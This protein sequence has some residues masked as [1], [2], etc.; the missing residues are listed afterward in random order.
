MPAPIIPLSPIPA[1]VTPPPGPSLV[2]LRERV[3]AMDED[4]SDTPGKDDGTDAADM[5]VPGGLPFI[6]QGNVIPTLQAP[7]LGAGN[8]DRI[9][10]ALHA[11]PAPVTPAE[12]AGHLPA[13]R[14]AGGGRVP[15][16][17][18]RGAGG[19]RAVIPSTATMASPPP[20][21]VAATPD[22]RAGPGTAVSSRSGSG[23]AEG[24]PWA[25]L[26]LSAASPAAPLAPA[27]DSSPVLEPQPR[28][29]PAPPSPAVLAAPAAAAQ[30]PT[31]PTPGE[32]P[33]AAQRHAVSLLDARPDAAGPP[34]AL[35]TRPSGPASDPAA[36]ERAQSLPGGQDV[37]NPLM[38]AGP[39]R[40]TDPAGS[41]DG[42][43]SVPVPPSPDGVRQALARAAPPPSP[44][45][46]TVPFQSWG[47]GHAVIGTWSPAGVSAAGVQGITLRGT[48]GAVTDAM[49]TASVGED[50]HGEATVWR[51][52]ASDASGDAPQ[53]RPPPPPAEEDA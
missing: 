2:P 19:R 29:P 3:Q 7:R 33:Q 10:E 48:S 50:A 44:A 47:D 4:R 24:T 12:G 5:A 37:P 46:I 41:P 23:G 25:A 38:A 1:G 17:A 51:I 35:P 42:R 32:R 34:T 39:D 9:I 11:L 8:G 36:R 13:D 6:V 28:M 30:P 20:P 27:G 45:T 15:P 16:D 26:P 53:R 14:P 31:A 52:A 40:Q 22:G 43:G 21:S 49:Q 18:G